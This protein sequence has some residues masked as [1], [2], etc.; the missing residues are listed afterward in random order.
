MGYRTLPAA[1]LEHQLPERGGHQGGRSQRAWRSAA[2]VCA[3]KRREHGQCWTAGE[4]ILWTRTSKTSRA[5]HP[6]ADSV[7]RP[8]GSKAAGLRADCAAK[9]LA[10]DAVMQCR[11]STTKSRERALTFLSSFSSRHF[12]GVRRIRDEVHS[13]FVFP[14]RNRSRSFDQRYPFLHSVVHTTARASDSK[15]I[16]LFDFQGYPFSVSNIATANCSNTFSPVAPCITCCRDLH[17]L[18]DVTGIDRAMTR[19]C[20]RRDESRRVLRQDQCQ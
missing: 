19:Q 3:E 5:G 10:L 12:H 1:V 11:T 18:S 9:R 6:N 16:E 13:T 7:E 2:A 4:R 17:H 20:L 8:G 15:Y 14:A